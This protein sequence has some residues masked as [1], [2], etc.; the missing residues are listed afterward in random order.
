MFKWLLNPTSLSNQL[1]EEKAQNRLL[2]VAL[3]EALHTSQ[4]LC[5]QHQISMDRVIVNR[6]DPPYVT[7]PHEPVTNH[8]LPI[9]SLSDVLDMDEADFVTQ[10]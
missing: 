2:Q 10:P 3:T 6:F 4:E 5:R 1:A 8:T 9:S 7:Q